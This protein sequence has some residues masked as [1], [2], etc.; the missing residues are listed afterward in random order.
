MTTQPNRPAPSKPSLSAVEL[1]LLQQ[2]FDASVTRNEALTAARLRAL[3]R[4]HMTVYDSLENRGRLR[5]VGA[6]Y[7]VAATVL[8]LLDSESSNT[9]LAQADSIY[10]VMQRHYVEHLTEPLPVSALCSETGLCLEDAALALEVMTDAPRWWSSRANDF[11]NAE[12]TVA[13]AEGIL[14]ND[15]FTEL[16]REV[17]TW[18]K[19]LPDTLALQA[20]FNGAASIAEP[21]AVAVPQVDEP[22][23]LSNIQA[24]SVL[25]V[26]GELEDFRI[27]P[28]DYYD[29]PEPRA[30]FDDALNGL[31][32]TVRT[33]CDANGWE[34]L[35]AVVQG[36]YPVQGDALENLEMIQSYIAPEFRRLVV[37]PTAPATP[38]QPLH[39][40]PA[41]PAM[42]ACLAK[43]DFYDIKTVVGLA[44]ISLSALSHLDDDASSAAA[45]GR[46]LSAIDGLQGSMSS[47][48]SGRFLTTLVEEIL[49]RDETSWDTL[50]EYLSRL[51]WTFVEERV[52][53]IDVLDPQTL[54]DTPA[55]CRG[56]LLKAAQRFRDGDL[57]GAVTS[58]CGAV[59]TATSQV[60]EELNLGDPHTAS[61][62]ERCNRAVRARGALP[63][64]EAQLLA[65]GWD[66]ADVGQFQKNLQSAL[67]SGAN[68][69]QTMRRKLGDVHGSK[70]VL[71]SLV[72]DC[73]RWAELI[74]GTLVERPDA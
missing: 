31:L 10:A 25:K 24:K 37:V 68:V 60:Y 38:K 32:K 16:V 72:F 19:G 22:R 17:N 52:V 53:P 9:L 45:K 73:L 61:F 33:Y 27:N 69:M 49:R 44:G 4:Q 58:A 6:R 63:A 66:A 57:N 39:Q 3:N 23:V 59:D 20:A 71:R 56:D 2:V 47:E 29:D 64:V 28:N 21:P 54:A 40:A 1:S 13:P 15:S 50:E 8:P 12:A 74:V 51:G 46:L 5:R 42:R 55:A 65:L 67:N 41:W 30:F 18:P 43:L 35:S 26:V 11:M 14:R 34:R 36:I 70:P 7:V 62:Q 48:N